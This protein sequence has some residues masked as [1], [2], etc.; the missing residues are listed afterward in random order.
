MGSLVVAGPASAADPEAGTVSLNERSATWAGQHYPAGSTALGDTI[1]PGAPSEV[2]DHFTLTVDVDAAHWESHQ[3]GVEVTISWAD[4]AN[5]FDLHVFRD[6]THV[7]HSQGVG[8]DSERVFVPDASGTYDIYV[9]P[10]EVVDSDYAGQAGVLSVKNKPGGGTG[11]EVPD[12]PLYDVPCSKGAA[13]PFPCKKVDLAAYLPLSAIGDPDA[14]N[15]IWGWTDPETGREY[16]LMG[17]TS[18]TSFIDVT[19]PSSPVYLG[20]LPSFQPVETLF[21]S[22]R[23]VKVHADHAYIVSEEPLHGMQVFD[24]TRLRGVTSEQSWTQ[25]AHYPLVGGAHNVAINEDSGFAYIIG[26]AT[27]DGGPHMV[28]I[29]EPQSPAFAGCV[30]EDGYTHDTQ[31]VIYDG[32]DTRFTGHEILFNSNEDTVT[33]VD[34]TDKANPVQLSRTGY[35]NASYTHQG[36]LTEDSRHFLFNDEADEQN[37]GINTTTYI[38]DVNRLTEPFLRGTYVA[39]NPSIDHNLY[40]KEGKVFEANYRSGLRILDTKRIDKGTLTEVGFFDIYPADDEAQFNG[41]WSNY[42]YFDS[43]T[44]IVSGIEQGLFVLTPTVR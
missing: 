25:D 20:M 7:D 23:D 21:A 13:G 35:E 37:H 9:N 41:A 33:I 24:L 34:I 6:G 39:D 22:W 16:A 43:G 1:C 14:G 40:T 19:E 11:G 26:S 18:G 27:C 38:L 42:P 32:P 28:D 31:A 36:W 12:E 3:G 17:T 30:A 10:Y 44:V 15:D 29:N 8:T 2:C 4:S 5:D